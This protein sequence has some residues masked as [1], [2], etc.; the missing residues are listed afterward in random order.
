M[1]AKQLRTPALIALF[2]MALPASGAAQIPGL[3]SV[4]SSPPA[5]EQPA[6]PLGRTTP[7]GTLAA[8]IRAVDRQ[9][10]VSAERYMQI[11]T[12]KVQNTEILARNLKTLLD[13]YFNVPLTR[14]SDAPQGTL[15][16]GLPLNQESIGHLT[17]GDRKIDVTLVRLTDPETGPI[18]Q[19]S[20]ETMAQV[21]MLH[22]FA[23]RTLIERVMPD[24]LLK[25]NLAGVALSNWVAL[26]A[27]FVIPFVLLALIAGAF[28]LLARLFL[29]NSASRRELDVWYDG[30]H[31]PVICAVTIIFQRMAMSRWGFDLG[32]RFGYAA[33]SQVLT[34]IAFTWLIRRVLTLG[35]ERARILAWGPGRA[36]TQSLLL[37]GERLVKA[38]VA[39][40]AVFAVLV[41]VGVD[42]KTALAGL[43]IG[44]V[45]LALGAQKTVENL[46]GGIFLLTDRV[47]AVGDQCR[48]ANRMGRVEDI[49]LRSVRLRTPEQSLVSVPAGVLAQAGIENFATRKKFLIQTTLPLRYGT[50]AEQIRRILEGIRALL[51][52]NRMIET[53][54]KRVRLVNFG[55]QAIELDLMAYV[56]TAN[57]SEFMAVRED[58]LLAV[59]TIVESAGT[60]FAQ[61]AQVLL[62][63]GKPG[64]P[65]QVTS[66]PGPERRQP[67]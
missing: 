7:R 10:F 32:F 66:A 14:I 51:D 45:A 29:K 2:W 26:V 27:S 37:L 54:T 20:A 4:P 61:P 31:W 55:G 18:W 41:I 13:H 23:P 12:A 34:V 64:A 42:T 28:L 30:I 9:D 62:T 6:D 38:L 53:E 17:I 40:V 11:S 3:P 39:V 49:T 57:E 35:F 63:N 24:W 59:T 21:P 52:G 56:L 50:N 43:G 48:I 1:T 65:V 60:G 25:R 36:N 19:I 8:F 5:E 47:I 16:D 67:V 15:E 22:G 58:L 46:L 44:G 33:V